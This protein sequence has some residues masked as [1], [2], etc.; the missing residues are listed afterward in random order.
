MP[1]FKVPVLSDR[2]DATK[3]ALSEAGIKAL[4]PASDGYGPNPA[5]GLAI[6]RMTALV[7]AASGKA[8]ESKVRDAAGETSRSDQPSRWAS[9]ARG[10][11]PPY[12]TEAICLEPAG[13]AAGLGAQQGL[14]LLL[15]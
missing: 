6:R 9:Q 3:A 14:A 13:R 2:P 10:Y 5:S 15:A 8:A 1:V 11:R 4:G 12:R 7:E